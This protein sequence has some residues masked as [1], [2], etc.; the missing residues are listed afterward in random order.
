MTG[1][2]RVTPASALLMICL[3]VA[4]QAAPGVGA[5]AGDLG[6]LQGRWHDCVRQ[7]YAGQSPKQGKAASQLSALDAC[8]EHEDAYVAAILASQAA[9]DEASRGAGRVLIGRAK[10]WASSTLAYVIEPVSHWFDRKA[11]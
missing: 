11:R 9:E 4:S 7:T 6:D 8:K 3:T 5:P 1:R 2:M 10:A